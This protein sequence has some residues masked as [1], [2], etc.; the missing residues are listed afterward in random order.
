MTTLLER[1]SV[2]RDGATIFR[3]TRDVPTLRASVGDFVI[4]RPG[5]TPVLCRRL[6]DVELRAFVSPPPQPA[7]R[8][9]LV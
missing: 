5:D 9:A 6:S 2:S 7:R 4:V 3:C 1:Q 8:L